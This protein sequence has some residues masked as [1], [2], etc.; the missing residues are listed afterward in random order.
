MEGRHTSRCVNAARWFPEGSNLAP[1]ALHAAALPDELENQG[2]TGRAR[3]GLV[4]PEHAR[5]L[6]R[7]HPLHV[8]PGGFEPP[9]SCSQNMRLTTRLWPVSGPPRIRTGNL[10]LAGESLC[11]LELAAHVAA[12]FWATG[13][14]DRTF[15]DAHPRPRIDLP[16]SI[17]FRYAFVNSQARTPSG[18]CFAWTAGIEPATT[19]FGDQRSPWLSYVHML[20][21]MKTARRAYPCERLLV[22][23][24][25]SIQKP[26]RRPGLGTAARTRA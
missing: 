9:V 5:S 16:R 18:W 23:V 8:W 26:P 14:Q 15:A 1:A 6:L 25:T 2:R 7:H 12:R 17:A 3:T 22:G 19:G 20:M 21:N 11:Q 13:S 24:N 4:L 10:L